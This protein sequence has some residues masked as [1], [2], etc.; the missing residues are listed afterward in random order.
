MPFQMHIG[1]VLWWNNI[2]KWWDL[3][4]ESWKHWRRC[5]PKSKKDL[6]A[7]LGI[8]NYL[9]KFSPRTADICEPLRKLTTTRTQ[10]TWN[11]TYQKIFDKAQSIIKED[12]CMKF[13]DETKP[14]SIGTDASWVVLGAALLQ[15]KSSTS[16]PRDEV[17]ENS[18][19]RPIAFASKSLSSSGKR[20]SN[21]EVEAL[22]ILYG[23][24]NHYCLTREVSINTDHKVLVTILKKT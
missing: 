22:C 19:L 15:T 1:C 18:F 3:T 2:Q 9:S 8:I 14:L 24:E 13:Y 16:C 7:V 12:A 20:Y 10:W 4:Q 6:Q 17:L 11:M 23:L 5:P 21:I